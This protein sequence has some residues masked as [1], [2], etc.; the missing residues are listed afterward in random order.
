MRRRQKISLAI[1][2]LM[3][4][5]TALVGCDDTTSKMHANYSESWINLPDGRTLYCI[6]RSGGTSCDWENA[7]WTR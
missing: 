5:A 3:V 6:D 7:K 2:G 4:G 1:V